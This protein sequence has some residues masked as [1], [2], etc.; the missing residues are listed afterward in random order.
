MELLKKFLDEELNIASNNVTE[1]FE[2]YNKLLME[3][4]AKIN[5]ISR[6]N[7]NIE[8]NILNSLYFLTEYSLKGNERLIDIGTGGGFPGIALKIIMPELK[9]TLNDS[10]KKKVKVL[11]DII[12][13]MQLKDIEAV[14]G[15][16]EEISKEKKYIKKF[17]IVI[18]KAVAD[19]DKL[20]LWGK[21]FL[22]PEGNML[23]LKGGDIIEEIK[24]FNKKFPKNKFKEIN[25]KFK[26]FYN[27]S[28][29]KLIVM[30]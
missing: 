7:V 18:S 6:K 27:I 23:A 13:K 30:K 10:I 15:R 5:L 29:K 3:W 20:Y 16:A 1:Q 9:I 24:I 21:D 14:C 25:F 4:N 17:D 19:L 12:V 8:N 11:E 28:D 22:K 26:N 2:L